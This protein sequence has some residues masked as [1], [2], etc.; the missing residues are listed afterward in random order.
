[1]RFFG[2]N[3]RLWMSIVSWDS[4]IARKRDRGDVFR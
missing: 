3:E 2:R 4:G 1:M